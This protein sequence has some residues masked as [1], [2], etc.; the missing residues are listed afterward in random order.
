MLLGIFAVGVVGFLLLRSVKFLTSKS[1]DD[2][3]L[4]QLDQPVIPIPSQAAANPLSGEM[5][6]AT[7]QRVLE[8]WLD[9]KKDAMGQS[10]TVEKLAQVLAEPR[11]TEWRKNAEDAKREN[12]Y[13]QYEHTVKVDT[14]EVSP[15]NPSQATANATIAETTKYYEG[16]QLADT[17]TDN[18]QIRYSLVLQDNQWRIKDWQVL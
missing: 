16:D 8:F 11:L 15:T 7:A 18:L 13:K 14:V 17:K 4:V 9:A 1:S 10:H 2:H 12:W 3:L 5:N 6:Q